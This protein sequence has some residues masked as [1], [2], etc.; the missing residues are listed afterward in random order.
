L[1][2]ATGSRTIVHYRELGEFSF[3][4]FLGVDTDRYD[5]I[6]FEARNMTETHAM[7]AH[8]QG[9]RSSVRVSV[10]IEK[11]RPA[12]ECLYPLADVLMFSAAFA[13]RSRQDTRGFLQ[14]VRPLAPGADLFCSRGARG[15]AALDKHNRYHEEPAF[16]PPEVIDTAGA[17]DTFNAGIIDGYFSKASTPER[18]AHACF[19]AGRK[20]GH[21]G[22]W[23]AGERID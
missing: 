2:Q 10:E 21:E 3:D 18:L 5:W 23:E 14:M 8:L 4:D 16:A 12:V 9:V 22:L 20:C 15:A 6:H 11:A 13:A 17:G 19:L 1:S 7:L